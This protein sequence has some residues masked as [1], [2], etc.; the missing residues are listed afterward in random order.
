MSHQIFLSY[1]T[2]DQDLIENFADHLLQRG[3]KAWVYSIDKTLSA[4]TWPEI[5]TRI[6]QAELFAFAASDQSRDA[7]GQHR[8]LE[9]AVEKVQSE[10]KEFRLLPIVIGDVAFSELPDSLRSI[11]G[12]RLN[13]CVISSTAQFVAKTFFPELFDHARDEP[14]KFPKPGEWLEVCDIDPGIEESFV[15]GDQLYFRRLSPLGLFEC[16]SP[17]LNGLFWILPDNVRFSHFSQEEIPDVPKEFRYNTSFEYEML[18]RK[19]EE[20]R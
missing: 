4:E 10:G 3:I 12:V 17:K 18:G 13:A 11:N 15:L 6:D 16:Y 1:A 5:K 9:M 8:E 19:M 20:R 14:W 2:L 7:Q